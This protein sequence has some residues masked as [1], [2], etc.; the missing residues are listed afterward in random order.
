MLTWGL[1]LSSFKSLPRFLRK[2]KKAHFNSILLYKPILKL[3][4]NLYLHC[5]LI[6]AHLGL[7]LAK[8]QVFAAIFEQELKKRSKKLIF[9]LDTHPEDGYR[10]NSNSLMG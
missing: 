3:V 10:L 8:V 9:T 4:K 6:E 7:V 2:S 5:L 1:S